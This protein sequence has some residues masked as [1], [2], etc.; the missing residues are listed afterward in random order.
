M[1]LN[2]KFKRI[3]NEIVK[4]F[5]KPSNFCKFS[6]IMKQKTY[7]FCP[8]TLME[9]FRA[10]QTV[11]LWATWP[12][13]GTTCRIWLTVRDQIADR[14]YLLGVYLPDLLSKIFPEYIQHYIRKTKQNITNK[15]KMN[16]VDSIFWLIMLKINLQLLTQWAQ[17][18]QAKVA[19]VLYS[20]Y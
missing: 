20:I 19:L 10:M 9:Q 5:R 11:T 1:S 6:A 7:S 16:I 8:F 17:L 3:M 2:A 12:E 4:I 14:T 15:M 18:F 13:S